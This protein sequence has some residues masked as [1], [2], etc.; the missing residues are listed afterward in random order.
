M[1]VT[2]YDDAMVA[3]AERR[4]VMAGKRVM[5]RRADATALPFADHSFDMVLSVLML[6]HVADRERALAE[7]ARVLR[8]EGQLVGA[9]LLGTPTWPSRRTRPGSRSASPRARWTL[10]RQPPEQPERTFWN[11]DDGDRASAAQGRRLEH[12]RSPAISTKAKIR[13]ES[14]S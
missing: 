7:A 5:V 9:D 8:P 12:S 3:A 6:H 13:S 11:R 14:R 4:L 10:W 2:D 1:T